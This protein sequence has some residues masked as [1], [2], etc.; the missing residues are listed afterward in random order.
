MNY[1]HITVRVLAVLVAALSIDTAAAD[2]YSVTNT[3]DTGPG[4]FRQAIL[5]SR[6]S[7][8]FA[9]LPAGNYTAIVRGKNGAT[10]IAVVEA[11]NVSPGVG[12]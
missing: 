5:D 1:P 6:E 12:E 3:M 10:G 4:S 9:S 8:I 2:T 11:Y 7:A